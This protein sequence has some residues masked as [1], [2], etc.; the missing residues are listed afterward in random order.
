M[1]EN[2]GI[3]VSKCF[4]PVE[5]SIWVVSSCGGEWEDSYEYA[6]AAYPTEE[7]AVAAAKRYEDE[8][9]LDTYLGDEDNPVYEF[10]T[11][12]QVPWLGQKAT[13]AI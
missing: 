3:F 13:D 5:K 8:R 9:H 12:T 7:E 2:N 4:D 1:T 6:F 10:A 11:V